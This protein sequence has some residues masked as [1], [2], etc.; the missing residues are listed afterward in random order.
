L[1]VGGHIDFDD[2]NWRF[3]SSS[4]DP[5]FVPETRLQHTD[6]QIRARHVEMFVNTIV[7]TDPRYRQRRKNKIFRKLSA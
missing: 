3:P 1:R 4:P 7:R 5:R 6:A 2:H